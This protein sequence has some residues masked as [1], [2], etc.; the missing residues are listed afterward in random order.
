M[1]GTT[2]FSDLLTALEVPHTGDYSDRRF[3]TMPFTT[4]F[5]FSRLLKEYGVASEGVQLGD[6][7]QIEKIPAPFLA[8]RGSGFVIVEKIDTTAGTVTYLYYH[9]RHT[10]ALKDFLD[11]FTGTVLL[12]YPD[13]GSIEPDYKKNHFYETAETVKKWILAVIAI[14]LGTVGF[15]QAGIG[16]H[17]SLIFLLATDLAGLAVCYLLIL[18]SMRV[19]SHAADKFCGILQKHGCDTVLEQK[20]SSFFGLVSWAQVGMAYFS[21]STLLL[22]LFPGQWHWLALVNGCCLPFTVWSISYQK[23]V[24]KTWCTLCVT[25][26]ALLWCQFF[27]FLSGGWWTGLW[28]LKLPLFEMGAAYL[29]V[30]LG[31]NRIMKRMK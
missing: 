20:A 24:I 9:E 3:R 1:K 12:A 13:A 27:C 8:Q 6:K 21:V 31:L 29:G 30:L 10:E 7:T 19:K 18:K 4:L 15:I 23:F 2:I 25:V 22:F 11:R 28:P 16:K 26:Q 14:F 17:L 5:G